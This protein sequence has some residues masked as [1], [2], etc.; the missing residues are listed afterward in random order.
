MENKKYNVA[1]IGAGNIGALKDETIDNPKTHKPLTHAHAIYNDDRFNLNIFIDSDC[2][3]I[4]N[5]CDRW[6]KNKIKPVG[7][8]D[9]SRIDSY[10]PTIIVIAANT[11]AHF[12][13]LMQ[14]I[15]NLNN[16]PELIIVEKP[17][18]WTSGEAALV[19][20]F[21]AESG[22]KLLVNYNRRYSESYQKFYTDYIK[23]QEV[24]QVTIRYNRGL[25]H[26][27]CH[28]LDIMNWWFGRCLDISLNKSIDPV[29]DYP[30]GGRSYSVSMKYEH[31][32]SVVF[33]PMDYKKCGIFEMDI[34]TKKNRHIFGNYGEYI[35]NMEITENK[36]Y[37]QANSFSWDIRDIHDGYDKVDKYATHSAFQ[38]DLH[39]TLKNLYDK[40]YECLTSSRQVDNICTVDDAIRVHNIIE[41][42]DMLY[43]KQT[44]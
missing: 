3:K 28:A 17:F 43:D 40:A 8:T 6:E 9:I 31:C 10:T 34:I 5:A 29:L 23:N 7:S 30:E 27:G 25:K 37:G 42:V 20:R 22:I 26:D 32:P 19:K 41:H 18:C 16:Q 38:T 14:D 4:F 12:N 1:I 24:Q 11:K 44:W 35:I 21:Y 15:M 33:I 39:Y 13:I 2:D 36:T